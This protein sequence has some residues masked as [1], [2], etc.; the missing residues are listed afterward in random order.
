MLL[1]CAKLAKLRSYHC[2]VGI[3]FVVLRCTVVLILVLELVMQDPRALMVGY[4]FQDFALVAFTDD[5]VDLLGHLLV[6]LE[7]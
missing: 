7:G 6:L 1:S 5:L 3:L 2:L 4:S